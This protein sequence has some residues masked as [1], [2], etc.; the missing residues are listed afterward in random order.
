MNPQ[1]DSYLAEGCGRCSYWRTPRCK[2]HNWQQELK[3]LR[4]IM[5]SSELIEEMKWSVPCYTFR[6]KN[7]VILSAFK[8]YCALSFFKGT[9]LKDPHG[10]L[11]KPGENSQAVRLLRFTTLQDVVE[12]ESIIKAYIQEAIELEKSGSQV[13]FKKTPEPIP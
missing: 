8:E 3:H 2:V 7:V 12:K 1:I 11:D 9:L 5:I 10:L 4:T 6:N 13:R